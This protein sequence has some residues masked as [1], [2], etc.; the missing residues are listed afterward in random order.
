M[1]LTCRKNAGIKTAH[2]RVRGREG[3]ATLVTVKQEKNPDA[4]L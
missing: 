4:D 1:L 3:A 2:A